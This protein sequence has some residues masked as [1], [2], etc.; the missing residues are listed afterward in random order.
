M[1][2]SPFGSDGG[3]GITAVDIIVVDLEDSDGNTGTGFS[4]VLGGGGSTVAVACR[5]LL[6]RYV[7]AQTIV[8]P[9]NFLATDGGVS[10]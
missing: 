7:V 4:Y 8:P 10:Q 6:N 3:S 2:V 5:D 9:P 1:G